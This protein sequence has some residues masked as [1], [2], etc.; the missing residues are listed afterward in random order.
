MH[1]HLWIPLGLAAA[2]LG[3]GEAA[4]SGG[5][6]PISPA[7]TVAINFDLPPGP[8]LPPLPVAAVAPVPL[9]VPAVPP[10][11]TGVLPPP[12]TL[13]PTVMA[14]LPLDLFL[15]G[16]QALVAIAIGSAEG[17]RTPEGW[18]TAAYYGHRDPGNGA[19]N[20]GS[21]SSQQ[22]AASPQAADAIELQRLQRHAVEL[23]QL[24]AAADLALSLNEWLNGLDLANQAPAAA[25]DRGYIDWL[26]QA[27]RLGLPE[28]EAILWARTR[29]FLDPDSGQWNAPGLGNNVATIS[30]DQAR[31]QQAIAQA[32]AG[33]RPPA[34]ADLASKLLPAD[35]PAEAPL[36]AAD[37]IADYV[38]SLDL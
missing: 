24:A 11:A 7:K 28:A 5:P 36:A 2:T 16:D 27:H 29:A 14:A 15:G 8:S 35:V 32:L 31:R 13:P 20:L 3:H 33:Y 1:E 23:A 22:G 25:L 12:P 26:A 9:A 38:I 17:T 19:W 18:R 21:F 10:G 34:P 4:S 37:A 30:R 6:P